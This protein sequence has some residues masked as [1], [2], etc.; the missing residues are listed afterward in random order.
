MPAPPTS[1]PRKT[2]AQHVDLLGNL[3]TVVA[4]VPGI[5]LGLVTIQYLSRKLAYVVPLAFIIV[6]LIPVMAGVSS[7]GGIMACMF[8]AHMGAFTA[9]NALFVLSPE[10]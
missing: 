8:L 3:V 9:L 1:P 6:P 2:Q 5:A 10:L 4:E 7:T